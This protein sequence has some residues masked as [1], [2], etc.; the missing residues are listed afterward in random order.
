MGQL[1][2]FNRYAISSFRTISY[3]NN[4]HLKIQVK[5]VVHSLAGCVNM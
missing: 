1:Q 2:N 3:D 5:D 4:S